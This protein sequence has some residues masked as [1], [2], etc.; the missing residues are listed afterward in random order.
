MDA[1]PGTV[2]TAGD[3]AYE[4]GSAAQFRDCY[5]PTWGRVLA[6]TRPAPG[7]HDYMTKGA[8]G[9]LGYFG[10]VAAPKGTTWY[11]YELGTWHIVVLD[12]DCDDIG[13]CGTG[14]AQGQWLSADLAASTAQCTIAIWHH[15]LF[16]SGF[17][18]NDR[19][20]APFWQALYDDGADVVINGHD[21]DYERFAPQDPAG[22]LDKAHGLR[23]FVVGTGGAA[24]RGFL[25]T[26]ANSE[27]R[28]AVVHGVLRLV[29]H[30]G[31]F[32]WAFLPT[33][34]SFSDSGSGLCH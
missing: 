31:S 34:G 33:S 10:T 6:R 26:K 22:H 20:V 25:V 11:S 18:G 5:G 15:P 17:H 3:N 2:F 21:H 4:T 30:P 32:E 13:G 12:S 24:L 7:N 16:S 14:S 8:A 29:L 27:I 9:Y 23:E 28:T 19:D 1:I